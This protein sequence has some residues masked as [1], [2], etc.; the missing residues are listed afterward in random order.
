MI[1]TR[2]AYLKKIFAGKLNEEIYVVCLTPRSRIIRVE[3][4]SN[5][6]SSEAKADM[7]LITD[8]MSRHKVSNIIV[9]HNHPKG[10]SEPSFDDDKF[11]KAL[12]ATLSINGSHILDHLIIAENDY[13]SY[14]K[15]GKIEEYKQEVAILLDGKFIS[16]P[17]AD[18]R[19]DV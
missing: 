17:K 2:S 9:A 14:R 7:R 15:A 1:Y 13:Y 6:T 5:G 12:V 16:Q 19:V 18:Y 10:S 8:I 3:K 4:V 11:T